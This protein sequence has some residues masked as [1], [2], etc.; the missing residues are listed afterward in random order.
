VLLEVFDPALL[1]PVAWNDNW[2]VGDTGPSRIILEA[3]DIQGT[4]DLVF[5][6][7]DAPTFGS[8]E[9]TD[10]V[11]CVSHE[12]WP[13]AR[14]CST[15]ADY[16]PVEPSYNGSTVFTFTASDVGMTSD[17]AE[18]YLEIGPNTAP[19]ANDKSLTVPTNIPTKFTLTAT[20]PDVVNWIPDHLTLEVTTP[21][22]EGTLKLPRQPDYETF[23]N[24]DTGDYDVTYFWL[25]EYTPN[26]SASDTDYFVFQVTDNNYHTSSAEVDLTLREPVT[27]HV[28]VFDDVDDGACESMQ[29]TRSGRICLHR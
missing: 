11:S 28:N 6:I 23:F 9:L 13:G 1:P 7:V 2:L 18:I 3:F 5:A 26:E 22:T 20:D 12:E 17:P 16:T 14:I 29:L 8:I 27:W 24:P 15:S 25:V 19:T 4:E 10:T 21:P